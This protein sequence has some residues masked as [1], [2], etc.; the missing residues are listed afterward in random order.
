MTLSTHNQSFEPESEKA[1]VYFER[2]NYYAELSKSDSQY[3]HQAI[4]D[5]QAAIRLEPHNVDFIYARGI[6]RMAH[7][8]LNEA[9]EDFDLTI[10][11]N[12]DFHLAY[13][14]LG[15]ILNQLGMRDCNM[16]LGKAAIQYF[17]KAA[18][19]GNGIAANIIGKPL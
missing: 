2:A 17:Q 13:H 8:K 16:E 9:M 11:L 14:Q 19:L 7:N 15:V 5:Y 12:P 18:D 10:E 1:M 6:T 4:L 3:Y